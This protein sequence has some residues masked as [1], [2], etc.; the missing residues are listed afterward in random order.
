MAAEG[1][2]KEVYYDEYCHLCIHFDKDENEWPCCECMANSIQI[3]SH[4]PERF[5]ERLQPTKKRRKKGE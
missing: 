3:N 1:E 5:E 2:F 4:I